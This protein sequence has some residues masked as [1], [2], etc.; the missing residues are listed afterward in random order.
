MIDKKNYSKYYCL[1]SFLIASVCMFF[2]FGY[3]GLLS[4]GEFCIIGGDLRDN[5]IPAIRNMC[6]DIISGQNIFYTWTYGMGINTSLYNA[7]YAYSP[8]NIIYLLFYNGDM[9]AVTIA[10]ILIKV[11]LSALC[12][13]LFISKGYGVKGFESVV[14]AVFYSLCSYQIA[15]NVQNIIWLDAMIALPV[16]FMFIRRLFDGGK[17]IYLSLA[18]GFIFIS[19]FYMGYMIGV[20]SFIYFIICLY[21]YGNPEEKKLR[22][23]IKYASA[24]LLAI[25]LSAWVWVPTIFFM[26]EL[27]GQGFGGFSSLNKNVLDIANQLFWG[28]VSGYD[29]L[30]PYIYCGVP[31]A[32]LAIVYFIDKKNSL[33]ERIGYG[34]MLLVLIL[35][36]IIMPLYAA[37]HGFDEP[38]SYEYRF[39]FIISFI[40]CT[41]AA[42]EAGKIREVKG[43]IWYIVAGV[44]PLL[45]IIELFWQRSWV[46]EKFQSNNWMGFA[47]N[48]LLVLCWGGILLLISSSKENAK[49][50]VGVI[51]VLMLCVETVSNGVHIIRNGDKISEKMTRDSY[52]TWDICQ[53]WTMDKL[54]QDNGFYRVC[55]NGD[56]SASSG[57]NYGYKTV[58][59]F[60]TADNPSIRYILGSLGIWQTPR[61][62]QNYGLTDVTKMLLG[63]KYDA[64]SDKEVLLEDGLVGYT[65]AMEPV[66]YSLGIG[67]MVAG[68]IDDYSDFSNNAFE[69]NN[70]LLSMMTGEEIEVFNPVEGNRISLSGNGLSLSREEGFYLV[71]YVPEA[72]QE[73][74]D[75]NLTFSVDSVEDVYGYVSNVSPVFGFDTYVVAGGEEN[76][77]IQY[78]RLCMSYI[79][80]LLNTEKGKEFRIESDGYLGKE[81]FED[82]FFYTYDSNEIAKAYDVLSKEQLAV[83]EYKDGYIKGKIKVEG[84][85]KILFTTIPYEKGWTVYVNGEKYNI[86][87]ILYDSLIA[88][89]LPGKG[90][91]DIEFVFKAPGMIAGFVISGMCLLVLVVIVLLMRRK[92]KVHDIDDSSTELKYE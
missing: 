16:I 54:K 92:E 52:F 83:D 91:Y 30:F 60:S 39:S 19:Q 89:E 13:Q 7:Y 42:M 71:E 28:E 26:S 64:Y 41:L 68:E 6:R 3:T 79:K 18:Y 1:Y 51:L 31:T 73:S 9:N 48:I 58:S 5:Y 40:L 56:I 14:F 8:F 69:N 72:V 85:S 59:F 70:D 75:I 4:T 22:S 87:P 12:F 15:F 63:V 66:E 27:N 78:G 17:W 90:E 81:Y 53:K 44:L 74:Q 34:I 37:W 82:I 55:F 86:S 61:V 23:V 67:Y 38:N 80:K 57:T 25:G 45:Y 2:I 20:A 24:V 43:R 62:V 33:K 36:C 50:V 46:A 49:R 84:D 29:A 88:L 11:G 32:I 65:V 77:S 10:Y 47:I 76:R 35:S 21:V